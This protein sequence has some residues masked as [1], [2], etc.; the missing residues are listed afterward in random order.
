MEFVDYFK[1]YDTQ[2]KIDKLAKRYKNKKVA[3]YGAGL[4]SRTLFEN[5]DL[6][7]LNIVAVADLKFNDES[8]R[9][10]FNYNC[11]PSNELGEIDCDVILIANQDYYH[12]LSI[13]DNQIL[14]RTKNEDVEIRPLFRLSYKDL[15][16]SLPMFFK[17]GK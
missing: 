17:K 8:K 2:K 16:C 12:F 11:I 10:F 6:S 13:L 3:I 4:Y 9:D 15:F 1:M 7:K 5:Y 14:F